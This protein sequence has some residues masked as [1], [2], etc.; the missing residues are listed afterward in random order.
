M[1]I[2]P[3]DLQ[4]LA[5]TPA[6]PKPPPPG[7]NYL[8]TIKPALGDIFIAHT[9]TVLLVSLVIAVFYFSTHNSRRKPIFILNIV[10]I[11]LALA[12]GFLIDARAVRVILSPL[13][14][15]PLSVNLAIGV[16]GAV[17]AILV[18]TVLLLRLLAVYPRSYIGAHNFVLILMFPVL[19]KVG[20]VINLIMFINAL[21]DATRDPATATTLIAHVWS[22][23]PYLKIEWFA[24]VLDNSYASAFF[25]WRLVLRNK[26]HRKVD[27]GSSQVSFA[28]RLRV[29][30]WIAATN[31][32]F[33]TFFSLAQIIIIYR[34]IDIIVVNDVVLVN[35]SIAVIGVVFATVWAGSS[36][37]MQ[38]RGDDGQDSEPRRGT[39]VQSALV[40]GSR[41]AT[42]TATTNV[43]TRETGL[44]SVG[45]TS[46]N[47]REP[48][49]RHGME[50]EESLKTRSLEKNSAA[51]VVELV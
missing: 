45:D 26:E 18:D 36:R 19:M 3:L 14:P 42:V 6:A 28:E 33:P 24:Q 21:A 2:S 13:N 15:P 16:L 29:L 47:G 37:W 48:P 8:A 51:A 41:H 49:A 17:Q 35:T 10:T 11:L 7:T 9:F 23:A 44:G 46:M 12:V 50:S 32:V 31:F 30:F 27:T 43:G 20:R 5:A 25:L 39:H 34:E 1:S 4:T 38:D 40:F 22:H